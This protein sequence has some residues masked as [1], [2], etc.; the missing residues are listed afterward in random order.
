M[1]RLQWVNA[2]SR[3]F[4]DAVATTVPA[5]RHTILSALSEAED[6][7]VHQPDTVGESRE[8]GTRFIFVAPLA[9]TFHV[10]ARSKTVLI[11]RANIRS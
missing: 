10:N 8:P 5:E 6:L 4:L 3:E 11:S 7:L 1:Y 9:I 2:A